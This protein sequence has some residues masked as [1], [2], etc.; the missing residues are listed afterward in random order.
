MGQPT[1]LAYF[2]IEIVPDLSTKVHERYLCNADII[3][4]P[5]EKAVRKQ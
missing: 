5:I 1:F 2:F 3:S 4:D